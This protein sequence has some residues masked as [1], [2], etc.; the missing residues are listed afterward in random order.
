M[1][2]VEVGGCPQNRLQGPRANHPR[3]CGLRPARSPARDQTSPAPAGS[4]SRAVEVAA[5]V[6]RPWPG[7]AVSCGSCRFT[8]PARESQEPPRRRANRWGRQQTG[9]PPEGSAGSLH[10]RRHSH[11][12][13]RCSREGTHPLEWA[14]P[15]EAVLALQPP[16]PRDHASGGWPRRRRTRSRR[17]CWTRSVAL[18]WDSSA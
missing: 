3:L 12:L 18:S 1:P 5:L 16:G 17:S 11:R 8:L 4:G 13:G 2:F 7:A 9:L 6:R 15:M 14:H 10:S